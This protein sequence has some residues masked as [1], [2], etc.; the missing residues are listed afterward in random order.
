MRLWLTL[1]T[2]IEDTIDNRRKA[3]KKLVK[4]P[5]RNIR[6]FLHGLIAKKEPFSAELIFLLLFDRATVRSSEPP[7]LQ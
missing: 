6:N 3:N 4:G 7:S 1:L 2:G 5:D